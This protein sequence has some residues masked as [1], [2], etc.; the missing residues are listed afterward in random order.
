[1]LSGQLARKQANLTIITEE[2]TSDWTNTFESESRNSG[3][4]P[5]YDN[6]VARP[7]RRLTH[8]ID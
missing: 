4:E 8:V 5:A 3:L 1:M 2:I 7:R 6:V